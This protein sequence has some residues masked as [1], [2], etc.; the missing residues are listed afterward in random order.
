MGEKVEAYR[1]ELRRLKEWEPYLKRHSGLPGP[2]ANLELV[3]AVAEEADADRLWRL[4]ASQDEFLALCGTAGLGRIALLEPETV[5]KWLRELAADP[6]WR[7]R[8]GVAIA[9]QRYGSESMPKLIAEMREWSRDGAYV[10]RAAIAG[11]CE[12]A[13]L[14]SNEDT[15]EVLAILDHVTRSLAATSD[16][17]ADAFKVLRKALGYCWSVAAA[18]APQNGRPYLEKWMR[19]NDRD[20]AWVLQSNL[21]KARMAPL[22]KLLA[23][24]PAPGRRSVSR[25][26][27]KPAA[28]RS[29]RSARRTGAA[30]P[31]RRRAT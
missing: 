14:K 24:T 8:E 13:L 12:P 27:S 16:R 3:A 11:L 5:M 4:S 7:V 25:A 21:G 22:R 20:V 19:S 30:R 18:A 31:R 26:R 10:Q 6:R 15:V 2:R 23:A 9:L 28:A 17:K 29:S 1:A